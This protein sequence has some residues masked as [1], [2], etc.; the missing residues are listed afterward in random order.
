MA[1]LK[2]TEKSQS[3]NIPPFKFDY[4]IHLFCVNVQMH[5][6]AGVNASDCIFMSMKATPL[7]A[8]LLYGT[9]RKLGYGQVF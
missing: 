6:V 2:F 5:G 1:G 9:A 3:L 4:G 8:R 7:V